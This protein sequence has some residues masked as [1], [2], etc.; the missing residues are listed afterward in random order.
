MVRAETR[1]V[2]VTSMVAG[3]VSGE[4]SLGTLSQKFWCSRMWVN[5]RVILALS[6]SLRAKLRSISARCGRVLMSTISFSTCSSVAGSPD[7]G[8]SAEV[9]T[10][11][12]RCSCSLRFD[13]FAR[14]LAWT[15]S[16]ARRVY[17]N[18]R[19]S[20]GSVGHASLTRWD[21]DSSNCACRCSSFSA[22]SA[23]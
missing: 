10:I 17:S 12:A 23:R 3:E 1:G 22:R 19:S 9:D 13:E 11:A 2:L 20:R 4:G 6:S 5:R 8:V 15:V 14:L 7:A 21:S 16:A 18:D